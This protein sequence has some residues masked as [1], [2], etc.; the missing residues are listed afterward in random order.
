VRRRLLTKLQFRCMKPESRTEPC[1]CGGGAAFRLQRALGHGRFWVSR[2]TV[3][4]VL[5][6]IFAA[7]LAL[8]LFVAGAMWR[9]RATSSQHL[10]EQ[11][12]CVFLQSVWTATVPLAA[13]L[14]FQPATCMAPGSPEARL[15]EGYF[16]S[17]TQL[18][19]GDGTGPPGGHG[20][21]RQPPRCHANC[22][23]SAM[24]ASFNSRYEGS[25][26]SALT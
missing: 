15:T 19:G 17:S 9:G 1:A 20:C 13:W 26:T 18:L 25:P 7:L 21:E 8:E 11:D 6:L 22:R 4:S 5:L 23:R 14:R 10:T 12:L 16:L 2:T 24:T 3:I